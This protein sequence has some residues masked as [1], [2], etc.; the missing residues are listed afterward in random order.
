MI[1]SYL[2]VAWR[3]LVRHKLY[4]LINIASLAVGIAFCTLTLLY[5][6]FEW[7]YDT[8]HE[9]AGRTYLIF[10]AGKEANTRGDRIWVKTPWP[11]TPTLQG[12]IPEIEHIVRVCEGDI[13]LRGQVIRTRDRVFKDRFT[14]YA[15]PEFFEV[16]SFPQVAGH[17]QTALRAP[18]SVVIS[19]ELAEVCFGQENPIGQTLALQTWDGFQDFS[20]SGVV[21]VPENS[22]LRFDVLL[23][24]DS[25]LN[26]HRLT[27]WGGWN[28]YTFIQLAEGTQEAEVKKKLASIVERYAKELYAT[29]GETE[30]RLLPLTG[31]H[32]ST[33]IHFAIVPT[34]D[35]TYSYI[36]AGMALA[37]LLIACVNFANLAI[38]LAS[39]RFREV[40]MRKVLGATRGQ[41]IGQFW[42]EAVLLSFFALV[43]GIVLTELFL[44]MFNGLV[45]RHLSLDYGSAWPVL[46]SLVLVTGLVAGSY[47]ALVLSGFHPV[48][49]LKGR[50]KLGGTGLFSRGLVVLQFAL[51]ILLMAGTLVMAAQMHYL[52]ARNLGF[53]PEQVVVLDT[54][55]LNRQEKARMLEVYRQTMAQ[56]ADLLKVSMGNMS[57]DRGDMGTGGTYEGRP[58]G[59][60]TFV[61]DYDYVETLGMEL[62]E[63]RD[64][65]REFATDQD[66]AILINKSLMRELGWDTAMGKRFSIEGGTGWE[67]NKTIIGVVRDFHYKPLRQQIAAATFNLRRGNGDLQYIFAR[68]SPQDIPAAMQLL[69]ETWSRVAPDLPFAYS[70][71]DEDVERQY[72]EDERWGKMVR[73]S[74]LFTISIACLGAFG[75]TSLT[76]ARRTKEI[77]IRKVLGASVPGIMALLSKE[78]TYLVLI[79]NLVAWPLAWYT[80]HRWLENFAYRIELG[81]GVF[82]LGGVLVLLIAWLTVS[83][84]AIRAARAN[85]VEALR[86]E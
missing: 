29:P 31:L 44:P 72:R 47:P 56:H 7:S 38:G 60:S 63:G 73:Y 52:Q 65:S 49:V 27:Q 82:V 41:L 17:L 8:F 3:N 48:V 12:H 13:E 50:M 34:S 5:V 39:T 1:R 51:S 58:I 23:P 16:F 25:T 9:K 68:I 79:A 67:K 75:L 57:F 64:F 2:I 11:L 35:P 78:F 54:F 66:Q 81:P 36:L 40:G 10:K 84:Q 86:Y 22:S 59:F 4:S 62:V 42:G 76:V 69:R 32:L 14:L 26:E 53:N 61:V 74:A 80:M 28:Y 85:P 6:R 70:F 20:V 77:G 33:A 45:D 21:E 18:N 24:F 71:L 55:G 83:W 30:L 43:L 15:E 46:G 37:V 19:R